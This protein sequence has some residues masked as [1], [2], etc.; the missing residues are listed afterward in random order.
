MRRSTLCLWVVLSIIVVALSSST[1][2]ASP[3]WHPNATGLLDCNGYSP[4]QKPIKQLPCAEIA[5]NEDDGF[6]DNGHYVGHDE[7]DIGWYSTQPGS[8]TAARWHV[9]LPVDPPGAPSTSFG[10][11]VSEF[12]LTVAPW[13]GMTLCD[14]ES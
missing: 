6:E 4:V 10:G 1:A 7:A 3:A 9:T 12:Q 11:P 2:S 5:A 8:S 14:N 13:F